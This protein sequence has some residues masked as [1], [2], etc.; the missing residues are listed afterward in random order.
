MALDTEV[1][2]TSS[3]QRSIGSSPFS[4]GPQVVIQPCFDCYGS[5]NL[6]KMALRFRLNGHV[7]VMFS[8][9]VT[10]GKRISHPSGE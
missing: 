3:Q 10:L 2:M 1:E 9:G 4:V 8:A 5:R 6:E 7:F